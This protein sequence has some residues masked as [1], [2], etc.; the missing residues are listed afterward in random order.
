MDIRCTPPIS[1]IS[2]LAHTLHIST[3]IS[4]KM[5]YL[6]CPTISTNAIHTI[7]PSL[8][9]HALF[10]LCTRRTQPIAT[11]SQPHRNPIIHDILSTHVHS[12]FPSFFILQTLQ[13]REI[14]I[15]NHCIYALINSWEMSEVMRNDSCIEEPHQSRDTSQ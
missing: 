2:L 15:N 10:F 7:C 11:P 14:Q 13:T 12:F 3:M 6:I 1:M 8:H 5:V 9:Y 4:A